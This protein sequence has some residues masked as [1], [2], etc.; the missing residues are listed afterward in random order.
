MTVGAS[1]ATC[2]LKSLMFGKIEQS[3]NSCMQPGHPVQEALVSGWTWLVLS[4]VLEQQWPGLPLL[5][6]AVLNNSNSVHAASTEMESTMQLKTQHVPAGRAFSS[7][8]APRADRI[9]MLS[10]SG[11]GA[12]TAA[13]GAAAMELSAEDML[14]DTSCGLQAEAGSFGTNIPGRTGA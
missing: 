6:S 7:T 11:S 13:D 14:Q 9:P 5:Y 4:E 3:T 2:I 8:A 12:A 1:H 10:V